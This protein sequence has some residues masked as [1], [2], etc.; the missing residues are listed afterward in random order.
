LQAVLA[1]VPLG[2]A[3]TR[4]ERVEV[5]SLQA[6]RLLDYTP[7]ELYGRDLL[8]LL[9][10]ASVEVGSMARQVRAQFAAHG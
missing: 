1:H 7:A 6:C 2:I 8:D 5:V 4:A 9:A 10:P 3:V